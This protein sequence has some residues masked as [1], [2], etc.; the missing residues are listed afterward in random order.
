MTMYLL[1]LRLAE[2]LTEERLEA[3]RRAHINL[4]RRHS[5]QGV[6]ARKNRRHGGVVLPRLAQLHRPLHGAA[7]H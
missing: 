3:A 5:T 1:D 7:G 2:V 6:P 4:D